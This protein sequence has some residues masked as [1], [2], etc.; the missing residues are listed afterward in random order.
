MGIGERVNER[1]HVVGISQAQLAREAGVTSVTMMRIRNGEATNVRAT[2]AIKLAK[3]LKCS[4][5]WLILGRG[6]VED[7]APTE[8]ISSATV[9]IPDQSE[10]SGFKA[11]VPI[12][13]PV[14]GENLIALHISDDMISLPNQ[15]LV[16]VE[17]GV[18]PASG[19]F[20]LVRDQQNTLL[21][22]RYRN[23]G[24]AIMLE[25]TASGIP[26]QFRY[27]ELNEDMSVIG[28]VA[29]YSAKP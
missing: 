26:E 28:R 10:P 19:E 1:M 15:C 4:I 21:V 14:D 24:A 20:A 25:A 16:F 6:P 13:S 5:N 29:A 7:D 23:M 2:T 11:T 27:T 17:Q 8:H 3:S 9:I 12:G 22:R 18:L